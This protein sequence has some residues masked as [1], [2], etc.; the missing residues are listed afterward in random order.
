VNGARP[1]KLV[2]MRE[3]RE[4]LR[5]RTYLLL[6]GLSLAIIVALT[7]IPTLLQS[8]DTVHLGVVGPT[9]VTEQ[10]VEHAERFGRRTPLPPNPEARS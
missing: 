3:I 9:A 6:F 8:D 2:A 1:V 7:V 4:G 10:L 5:N